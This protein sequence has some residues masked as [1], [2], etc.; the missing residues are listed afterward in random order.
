ME[1]LQTNGKVGCCVTVKS[2]WW[3]DIVPWA[4]KSDA[5]PTTGGGAPGCGSA[6]CG[7]FDDQLRNLTLFSHHS[8]CLLSMS[9]LVD[10]SQI[11]VGFNR[12]LFMSDF[13]PSTQSDHRCHWSISDEAVTG[14]VELNWI[15]DWFSGLK[16]TPATDWILTRTGQRW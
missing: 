11:S 13:T 9:G 6:T 14:Q 1:Q 2:R 5:D 12:F 10:K 4:T 8:V 15:Q 3:S 7:I 16:L